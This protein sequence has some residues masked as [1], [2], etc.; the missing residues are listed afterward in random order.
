M[1][2]YLIT[3]ELYSP[4]LPVQEQI[5]T[6]AI[7]TFDSW[8]KPTSKVWLIKTYLTRDQVINYLIDNS[9]PN[10]RLL[11]MSVNNDW[12]A[13]NLPNDVVNWMKS[14]L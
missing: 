7:K 6:S 5:I 8:A 11:V 13:R 1:N 2:T 3:F 12:I 10:D 14:G 4:S 9:G